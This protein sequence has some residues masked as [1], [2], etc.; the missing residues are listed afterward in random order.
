MLQILCVLVFWPSFTDA[1]KVRCFK[2]FAGG[3]FG[4]SMFLRKGAVLE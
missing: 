1:K 3:S 4:G 2:E